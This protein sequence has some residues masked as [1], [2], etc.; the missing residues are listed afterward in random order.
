[1]AKNSNRKNKVV[2]RDALGNRFLC[3]KTDPKYLSGEY[4]SIHKGTV[5][6]K[7][8]ITGKNMRVKKEDPRYLSGELIH[9]LV[10][11]INAKDAYGNIYKVESNDARL[12]TGELV[13]VWKGMKHKE[14]TKQKIGKTNQ[15]KQKGELNS[16]YQT[17]WISNGIYSKKVA[18]NEVQEWLDAGW[19]LGSKSA[20]DQARRFQNKQKVH[21]SKVQFLTFFNQLV[22]EYVKIYFEGYMKAENKKEFVPLTKFI[23]SAI[24]KSKVLNDY[25]VRCRK[26]KYSNLIL[27]IEYVSCYSSKSS[28]LILNIS[29]NVKQI[30][31][32]RRNNI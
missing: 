16:Q 4:V 19:K 12:A 20:N 17:K 2:V 30:L 14:S 29:E 11:K 9:T 13:H 7:D 3:D 21:E 28:P 8:P 24:L 10:G 1:M 18:A 25:Q 26:I 27:I 22:L 15:V 5:T 31:S 23:K 6:V 32:S